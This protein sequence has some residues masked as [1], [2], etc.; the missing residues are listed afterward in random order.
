LQRQSTI[1]KREK[2]AIENRPFHKNPFLF[3][4]Y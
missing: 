3:R 4:A 2:Y 1:E